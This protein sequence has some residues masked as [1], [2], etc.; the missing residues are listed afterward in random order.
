MSSLEPFVVGSRTL[1]TPPGFFWIFLTFNVGMD[2]S[3][4]PD[5]SDFVATVDGDERVADELSWAAEPEF[6][7]KIDGIDPIMNLSLTYTGNPLLRSAAFHFPVL[8]F[9]GL[10]ID[11]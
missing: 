9:E 4:L 1:E 8:P 3:V 11:L 2:I 6:R 5:A 10:V 7:I